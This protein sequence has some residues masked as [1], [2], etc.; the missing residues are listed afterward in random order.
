MPRPRCRLAAK[1]RG[2]SAPSLS[3]CCVEQ[4]S[5]PVRSHTGDQ[6]NEIPRVLIRL[7]VHGPASTAGVP[8]LPPSRQYPVRRDATLADPW[9]GQPLAARKLPLPV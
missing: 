1:G 2:S 4:F 5:I 3:L 9:L 8:T 6:H 7:E